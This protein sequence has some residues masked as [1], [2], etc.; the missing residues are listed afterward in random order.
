MFIREEIQKFMDGEGYEPM[1]KE[2]LVLHYDLP[3][4][5]YRMFFDLLKSMERESIIIQTQKGKYLLTKN[6][7]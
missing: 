4:S 5:E 2:E 7:S 1:T 3:I 6:S